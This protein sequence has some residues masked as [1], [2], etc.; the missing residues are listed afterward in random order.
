MVVVVYYKTKMFID[1]LKK[2]GILPN[3]NVN[4][5]RSVASFFKYSS[6]LPILA[7]KNITRNLTIN[8]V[9]DDFNFF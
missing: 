1:N 4:T 2:H 7:E 5:S 8:H 3:W 6:N 9:L